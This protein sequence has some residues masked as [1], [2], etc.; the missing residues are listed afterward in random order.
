MPDDIEQRL[1][2]ACAATPFAAVQQLRAMGIGARRLARLTGDGD[3]AVARVE[4]SRDGHSWTWQGPTGR[5][6]VA[7]RDEFAEVIDVVAIASHARDEWALL[8]GDGWALGLAALAEAEQARDEAQAKAEPSK[9]PRPVRLRVWATPLDWLAHDCSG[10]CVLD[11]AHHAALPR[12]RQLGAGVVLE[13][14]PAA[15]E[16]LRGMLAFG[17]LPRIEGARSGMGIAA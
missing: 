15:R 6:L 1:L 12:L 4:L 16:T 8:S 9:A 17:G 11:W 7:V 2:A 14:D 5:L 10:I 13:V 3:L